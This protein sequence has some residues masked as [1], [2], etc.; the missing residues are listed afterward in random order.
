M[1]TG[2]RDRERVPVSIVHLQGTAGWNG[3]QLRAIPFGPQDVAGRT[4][5]VSERRA[6]IDRRRTEDRKL[7]RELLRE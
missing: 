5:H 3:L 4:E 2:L 7:L 1:S 6:A